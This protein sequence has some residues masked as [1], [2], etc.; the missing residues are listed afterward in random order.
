MIRIESGTLRHMK[1]LSIS[2]ILQDI[3]KNRH[4]WF[5]LGITFLFVFLR[6]PSLIEPHW[7]GDEGI[8]QV[9]GRA[10]ASGRTLYQEIWDNKP[11]LLYF[12]YAGVGGD[13][14]S[15]RFLSLLMGAAST[16]VFFYLAGKLF[17]RNI[18]IY[19]STVFFALG[20]GLPLLEGNIANS[21]NFML[22]PILLSFYILFSL[23]RKKEAL[24]LTYAGILLGLAFLL[25]IVALFDFLAFLSF[26]LIIRHSENLTTQKVTHHLLAVIS[27]LFSRNTGYLQKK[28]RLF[29]DTFR[30]EALFALAF[31]A[32]PVL[33]VLY[34]VL[35]GAFPDFFKAAFSQNVG[36]VGYGNRFIF[37]MG[38]MLIKIVLLLFSVFLIGRY[39]KVLGVSGTFIYVWLVFSLFNA[40]FSE[41]PYTHY[42]LVLLPAASLL[43]GLI[44][45]ATRGSRFTLGVFLIVVI[46]S[47]TNFRLYKKIVPYYGNYIHFIFGNKSV[48]SYQSFFD[49]NTPRDYEIARFI[50]TKTKAGEEVF[51]WGDSAQ[52]YALSNKLPPGRYIV[53]YHI[54]FY[55]TAIDE[56]KQD[57]ERVAPRYIFEIKHTPEI[58]NFLD[59][60]TLKYII[61]DVKIYERES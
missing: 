37:P 40:F 53:A 27:S 2:A 29:F 42:L 45:D 11:P 46:L 23:P 19:V 34:F 10:L 32:L 49:R 61:R 16:M 57:I 60:Y 17:K 1:Q 54:T 36:Y 21:E 7:Y 41:R 12:L 51:L 55:K 8:Y 59:N 35:V 3:R 20:F 24:M 25:K 9:M 5:V 39:K 52:I 28:L 56:T 58:F 14:F 22:L 38:L 47:F 26:L 44:F 31:L 43:S 13:Q 6:I 18:S 50:N 48:E 4:I 15:I 33:T 30:F